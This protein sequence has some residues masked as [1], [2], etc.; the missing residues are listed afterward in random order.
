[1]YNLSPNSFY[2][3]KKGV[4]THSLSKSLLEIKRFRVQHMV[5]C[6]SLST[7]YQL[8]GRLQ[9]FPTQD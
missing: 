6:N 3:I 9:T 4:A 7:F 1:M 8:P 2:C 5:S